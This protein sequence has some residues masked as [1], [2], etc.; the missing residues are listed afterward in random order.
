MGDTGIETERLVLRAPEEADRARLV[1]LFTDPAF[2]VFFYGGVY[3][4][5]A[6]HERFD[7]M[8]ERCAE[9]AYAKQAV[10]ERSSGRIVGYTGVDW[11]DTRSGRALELGYRLE[12]AA[13]GKGYATEASQAILAAARQAAVAEIHGLVDAANEPS[14]HVLGKLGFELVGEEIVGGVTTLV[15]VLRLA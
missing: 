14:R 4:E 5:P 10:V 9:L 6:A 12:P 3:D 7:A 2:M 15:H 8:V 13:R 11:Y 1:E